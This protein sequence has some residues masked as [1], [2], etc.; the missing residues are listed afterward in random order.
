M[1]FESVLRA[2]PGEP[3]PLECGRRDPRANSCRLPAVPFRHGQRPGVRPGEL[4]LRGDEVVTEDS[5]RR[6]HMHVGEGGEPALHGDRGQQCVTHELLGRRGIVADPVWVNR[7]LL[8]TGAQHL[9]AKQWKRLG[10]M[11]DDRD[12]TK[13]IGA[14]WSAPRFPDS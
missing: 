8:L 4:H 1:P 10:A 6:T 14:A 3:F 5:V 7:R 11:L 12:P 13:E 9:S 2:K